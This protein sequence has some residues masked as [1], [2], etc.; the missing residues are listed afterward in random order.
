M[1]NDIMDDSTMLT[2]AFDEL[3]AQFVTEPA[4]NFLF[5]SSQLGFLDSDFSFPDS[6]YSSQHPL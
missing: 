4:D 1:P 3:L 2:D 6:Y 5:Q